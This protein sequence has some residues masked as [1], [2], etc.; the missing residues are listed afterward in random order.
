MHWYS[1][2]S[3][4]EGLHTAQAT[5]LYPLICVQLIKE[6]MSSVSF[7]SSCN[8]QSMLDAKGYSHARAG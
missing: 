5:M 8:V 6:G 2:G 7:M 4:T 1:M 3:V